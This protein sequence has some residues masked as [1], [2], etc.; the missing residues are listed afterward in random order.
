VTN[1]TPP[2]H[3]P[4]RV[5]QVALD[6]EA[7]GLERLVADLIRR[8]NPSRVESHLLTFGAPG[9]HA[10]GLE[11][12]ATL[13]RAA[14]SSPLSMLWPRKLAEQIRRIAPDVVHSHSG[15]WYK[16]SRA[17]RMAGIPRLIHTDHGRHHPDPFLDRVV[18]NLASRWTDIVVAVSEALAAQL[19]ASV[20]ARP[21]RLRVI[22]NGIDTEVLR[23]GMV[24]ATL[25][26]E[27]GL[28]PDRPIIGS[29]GRFDPIKGYDIM[30]AAYDSL[31]ASWGPS[32]V[33]VLALAG[34]GPELPR[35]R[36]LAA[37]LGPRALV[38]F[39]GWRTDLPNLLG[40]FS[41]F[42]LASHSEGTSLSLLEAMALGCC[43]VVT[44]V[45][46]NAA[47]LGPDLAHRLVPPSDPAALAGAWLRALRDAAGRARDVTLARGRVEARFSLD[48]MVCAYE[49]LYLEGR[50]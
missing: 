15:V 37:A 43:P 27:L 46:G 41:L 13:H 31:A 42:T 22:P 4:V 20:V 49:A 23:P 34:E 45:G 7:G 18:D 21:E 32:P 14:P 1:S 39:L 38:H 29:I 19:A 44:D 6:L 9:R 3:R 35:L 40:S 26:R 2:R 10:E 28:D 11:A 50:L 48:A 8:S 24:P 12:H 16:V 47:V 30:L 17:A 33:P 36:A 5:L 25:H